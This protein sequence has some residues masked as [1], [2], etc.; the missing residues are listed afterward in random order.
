MR[1]GDVESAEAIF[2]EH[3]ASL[4][5]IARRFVDEERAREVVQDTFVRFLERREEAAGKLPQWLFAVCKNRAI[6]VARR[7]KVR[8]APVA[9]P[10]AIAS[11]PAVKLD[12][13]R[14][15]R[16]IARLP[17]RQ[18]RIVEMRL[19]G[20]A[21]YREIAAALSISESNVGYLMHTA[22]AAI[23]EELGS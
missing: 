12:V 3:E 2:S 20:G 1:K 9:V 6:D 7:E 13:A 10:A 15:L 19:A 23:R 14:A 11:S 22:L 16:A 18:R 4:L 8:R 17:A 21:S 5:R